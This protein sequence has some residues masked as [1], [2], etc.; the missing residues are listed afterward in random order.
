[1]NK[2]VVR[3]FPIMVVVLTLICASKVAES[4]VEKI[5]SVKFC[6]SV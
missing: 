2:K 1:M 5:E 4:R 6:R 3:A